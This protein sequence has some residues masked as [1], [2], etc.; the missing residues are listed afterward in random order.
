[1]GLCIDGGEDASLGANLLVPSFL[2]EMDILAVELIEKTGVPD[3]KLVWCDSDNWACLHLAR[4][5]FIQHNSSS[6]M[7]ATVSGH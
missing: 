6:L 4:W 1:M 7:R 3:M 2:V 5:T